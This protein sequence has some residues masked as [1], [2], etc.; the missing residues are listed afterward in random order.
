MHFN[1][2]DNACI[3]INFCVDASEVYTSCWLGKLISEG[4]KEVYW[5]GLTAD[6]SEAYD[7]DSVRQLLETKVFNGK[8]LKEIWELITIISIDGCDVEDRISYYS[9]E[10]TVESSRARSSHQGDRKPSTV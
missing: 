1:I 10:Q 6:G 2:N 4:K 5:F 9:G 7:F 8:S 3:E